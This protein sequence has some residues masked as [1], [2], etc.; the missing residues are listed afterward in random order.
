MKKLLTKICVML[1]VVLIATSL[2]SFPATF[3]EQTTAQDQARAFI[4]NALPVDLSKYNITLTN[5]STLNE[6]AIAEATGLS[7]SNNRVID[8]VR[9]TLSSEEST[10]DVICKI[11]NNVVRY[12]HI[13]PKNGSVISNEQYTNPLDAVKSFLEKYQNY[14][15]IDSTNLIE[16]LDNV[17]ITKDSSI[18]VGNTKLTITNTLFAGEDL[19]KFKW[20]YT[21][22]GVDYTSLQVSFQ[23]NGIFDSFRDTRAVYTIGDTSINISSEQAIE[24]ALNYLPSYSYEMPYNTMVSDFNVTEDKITTALE[25]SPVN[26]PEMRPYWHVK[27]PLNQ[28]YPGSVQGIAVYIWANSGEI[29]SCSN[30][31]YGGVQYPDDSSDIE[32]DVDSS[33]GSDSNSTTSSEADDSILEINS[34]SSIDTVFVVGIAVAVIG[35]ATASVVIIKKRKK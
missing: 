30:I 26:Y 19:T 16:L 9:Y 29:I 15:K 12:C 24:I 28:T 21:V 31:A 22:N 5:H 8:T 7:P 14:T 23:K 35:L 4:E 32:G 6:T 34:S 10:V 33:D 20:A 25:S 2:G 17:D 11:E 18:T 27:L 13:Y 3:A 1:A